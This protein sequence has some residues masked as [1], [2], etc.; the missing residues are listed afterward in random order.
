MT[1]PFNM[2]QIG[3][4]EIAQASTLRIV[5]C[6]VEGTLITIFAG[7]VLRA[8]GL[9]NSGTRFAVWFAALVA[10]AAVP[11]VGGTWA[12]GAIPEQT[13]SRPAITVPGSWAI[14]LF[15]AWAAIAGWALMRVGRGLWHL[16]VLRKSCVPVNIESLDTGIQQTLSRGQATRRVAFCTSDLVH[17]PTAIG[18]LKPAV[19]VPQWVMQEL[20]TEELNQILLHEFAHLR[21][22]DDWTNLA[23]KI[24]K[25]LFFFHPAVW[26]IER[27]VSLEREMAC[28][29]AVLAET[30]SPRA[31]AECLAH[32]AEKTLIQRSVALAQAALGRIRHTSL[33]VAQILDGN[34]ARGASGASKPAVLLVAGFA[35]V[36]LVSV[37]A[38]PSLI[39]FDDGGMNIVAAA[40][41]ASDSP[42]VTT[43]NVS[44]TVPIAHLT[45]A[46]FM[47]PSAPWVQ[48]KLNV[49]KPHRPVQKSERAVAKPAPTPTLKSRAEVPVRDVDI[50]QTDFRQTDFRQAGAHYTD[51]RL[52]DSNVDGI[53][54]AF[55]KMIFV[56][57][58]GREN[59]VSNQPVYQIQ[60]WRLTVLHRAFDSSTRIHP[61]QT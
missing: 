40:T 53:P 41:V 27:K 47:G 25:A 1:A 22:W 51:A 21:R 9:R 34:R 61:K 44:P 4:N 37:S 33:R 38:A 49:R 30:A 35:A 2:V 28:D 13:L 60:L 31:Y 11:F 16:H 17:I 57:V 20:S 29:D 39:A 55:T 3:L 19:V 56:V 48:A 12:H 54:V 52:T 6:L 24:V 7:L 50:Q 14:Y 23:Q 18:L 43:D 26:W 5:D 45:N 36:C 59:G 8:A 42:E 32:L 10:I 46:K 58:E 15:V